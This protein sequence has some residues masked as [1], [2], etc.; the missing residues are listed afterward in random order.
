[1][2]MK[3]LTGS[4]V[5]GVA[6][7]GLGSDVDERR[8]KQIHAV[9]PV[10]NQGT[11]HVLDQDLPFWTAIQLDEH[12]IYRF[13]FADAQ[14]TDIVLQRGTEVLSP[15]FGTTIANVLEEKW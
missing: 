11:K 14:E 9:S 2:T 7:G 12:M 4:T 10:D 1:M 15:A 13:F 8:L 6:G 3:W 5:T